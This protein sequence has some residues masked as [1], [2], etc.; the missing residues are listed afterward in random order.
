LLSRICAR[1]ALPC[2]IRA[3]CWGC[4]IAFS[5][6]R[7]WAISTWAPCC[8]VAGPAVVD[9]VAPTTG[10]PFLS[11]TAPS[12]QCRFR[13]A[14]F[15]CSCGWVQL[16]PVCLVVPGTDLWQ[17][18]IVRAR[19]AATR[20]TSSGHAVYVGRIP[21]T[22]SPRGWGDPR[23]QPQGHLRRLVYFSERRSDERPPAHG[24]GRRRRSAYIHSYICRSA[25]CIC[26]SAY[27]TVQLPQCR[28]SD[29]SCRCRSCSAQIAQLNGRC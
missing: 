5:C 6:R 17:R 13:H 28:C 21:R 29:A 12:A 3:P 25:Q 22:F 9:A 19:A 16:Q 10:P 18:P 2:L 4:R 24:A 14:C 15:W 23:W 27:A 8:A 26:R 11:S 20:F 1:L 7:A